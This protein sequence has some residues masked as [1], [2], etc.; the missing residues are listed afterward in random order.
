MVIWSLD[1]T[2]LLNK[3]GTKLDILGIGLFDW[4][5]S[6]YHRVP[7]TLI[8]VMTLIPN[9]IRKGIHFEHKNVDDYQH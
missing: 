5:P 2:K 7:K 8:M 4:I 6:E 3:L 9:Y 1:F